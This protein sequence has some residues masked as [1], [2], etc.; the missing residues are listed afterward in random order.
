MP[1]EVADKLNYFATQHTDNHPTLCDLRELYKAVRFTPE[2]PRAEIFTTLY[3][4]RFG[5]QAVPRGDWKGIIS[6]VHGYSHQSADADACL[7]YQRTRFTTTHEAILR[8]YPLPAHSHA[9]Y[10]S[11]LDLREMEFLKSRTMYQQHVYETRM[12]TILENIRRYRPD[13]V[14]M[15]DMIGIN[16]LK[17]SVQGHF[18]GVKFTT[19]KAVAKMPQHHVAHLPNLDT[20]LIITTQSTGLK[21]NRVESGHDWEAFGQNVSAL[22]KR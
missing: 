14:V 1:E 17:T 9:W 16:T 20:T 10:Y 12:R 5:P 8:L 15:H 6:F 4:Y 3:D 19:V 21:H 18:L 7:D 22:R 11:W 13:V 2:R